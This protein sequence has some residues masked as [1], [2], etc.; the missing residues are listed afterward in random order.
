MDGHEGKE[1]GNMYSTLAVRGEMERLNMVKRLNIQKGNRILLVDCAF[2]V[3]NPFS[4]LRLSSRST[5]C[6][7]IM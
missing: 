7:I 3:T 2:C 4:I 1:S 5:F 6:L